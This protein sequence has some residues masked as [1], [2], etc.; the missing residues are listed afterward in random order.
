MHTLPIERLAYNMD[1]SL[2]LPSTKFKQMTLECGF[3]LFSEEVFLLSEE[4]LVSSVLGLGLCV[5]T[6][7]IFDTYY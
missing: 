6:E 5:T 1:A 2:L 3:L 4:V 7:V